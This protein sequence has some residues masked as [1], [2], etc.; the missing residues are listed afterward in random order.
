M[1]EICRGTRAG[2]HTNFETGESI[3]ADEKCRRC[4][5][6]ECGGEI[7][8]RPWTFPNA[9]QVGN[10]RSYDSERN[11]YP[12]PDQGKIPGFEEEAV[13]ERGVEEGPRRRLLTQKRRDA[14]VPPLMSGSFSMHSKCTPYIC[15]SMYCPNHWECII[16]H[17]EW[18]MSHVL[19][20]TYG[21]DYITPGP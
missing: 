18:C 2:G 17:G 4:R 20:N 9:E 11:K 13:Q 3:Q 10:R 8:R 7:N 6:D 16:Y 1:A 21:R 14:C 15:T 12:A 5:E 19:T